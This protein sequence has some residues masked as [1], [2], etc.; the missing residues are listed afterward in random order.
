[1]RHTSDGEGEHAFGRVIE[2]LDVVDRDQRGPAVGEPLEECHDTA[3]EHERIR[4][5]RARPGLAGEEIAE[6]DER[7]ILLT[8][9]GLDRQGLQSGTRRPRARRPPQG[10]LAEASFAIDQDGRGERASI[11]EQCPDHG[12]LMQP[13]DD[14]DL[15]AVRPVTC[16][17]A[18][19]PA[20]R[21]SRLRYIV[22][23]PVRACKP[24]PRPAR[25]FPRI[26]GAGNGRATAP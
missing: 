23:S 3:A 14:L 2:P 22:R 12:L 13:P 21:L 1:M 25:P 10:G 18:G 26:S 17:H 16:R 15:I 4:L 9:G 6:G 11:L 19:P 7:Q 8:L 20:G 24:H 5:V